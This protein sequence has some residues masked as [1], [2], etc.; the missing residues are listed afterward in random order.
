M[1]RS[2][3]LFSSWEVI[4]V[5]LEQGSTSVEVVISSISAG[6]TDNRINTREERVGEV[7]NVAGGS[8]G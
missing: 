3:F 4:N 5:H 2:A 6:Y 1:L 7:F 8:S